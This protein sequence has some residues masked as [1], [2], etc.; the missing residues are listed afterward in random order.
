MVVNGLDHVI[1]DNQS[2]V[3]EGT[4]PEEN[5]KDGVIETRS[6]RPERR[7]QTCTVHTPSESPK[8][9]R[10]GRRIL[11]DEGSRGVPNEEE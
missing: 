11:L 9:D 1:V 3:D 10:Q 5:E 4:G 7:Q 8:R 2:R 6:V